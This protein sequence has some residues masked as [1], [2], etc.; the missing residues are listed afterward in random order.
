MSV[1]K[2]KQL[3]RETG[4]MKLA[5]KRAKRKHSQFVKF[6]YLVH[7]IAFDQDPSRQIQFQTTAVQQLHEAA[8]AFMLGVFRGKNSVIIRD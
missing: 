6:A 7:N 1:H 3:L 8:Q 4:C 5:G 2:A